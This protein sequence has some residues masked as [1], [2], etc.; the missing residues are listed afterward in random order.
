M[1]KRGQTGIYHPRKSFA[2]GGKERVHV[3][4]WEAKVKG[5]EVTVPVTLELQGRYTS[6]GHVRLH[7]LDYLKNTKREDW[8]ILSVEKMAGIDPEIEAIRVAR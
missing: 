6:A 8:R 7:V 4:Q 3:S 5:D 2:V 1:F